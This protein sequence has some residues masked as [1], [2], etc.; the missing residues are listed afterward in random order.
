MSAAR[1][2]AALERRQELRRDP[3]PSCPP[4][5]IAYQDDDGRPVLRGAAPRPP[6]PQAEA[7]ACPSC[8]L[9][10]RVLTVT[11]TKHWRG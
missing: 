3:C 2:I 6:G 11:Y 7:P 8:G 9:P 10:G 4:P 5:R 1:R